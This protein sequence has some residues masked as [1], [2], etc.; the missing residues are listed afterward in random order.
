MIN[1]NN[2]FL[3]KLLEEVGYAFQHGVSIKTP[4]TMALLPKTIEHSELILPDAILDFYNQTSKLEVSWEINNSEDNIKQFKEDSFII[5]N[6][7]NNNYDWGVIHEYLSGYINITNSENIFNPIFCK[8]QAYYYTLTGL[9][10]DQ[11]DFFPFDIHWSLTACL[12]KEENTIIDNIWLVHTDAETMHDM[13][14]T[15]E[16]YLNLAYQAK[17]FHYW[18]L[19]YLFKE[20]VEYHAIMKQFLP[21]ILPHVSLDLIEFN[22]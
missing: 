17:G 22:I 10:D 20:K 6:Y 5:E 3:S 2:L 14:I 7:F 16:E 1:I 4:V 21:K 12:K 19:I 18:Q 15:I 13:K 11:D 8:R 9:D